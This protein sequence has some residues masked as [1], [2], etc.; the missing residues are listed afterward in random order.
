MTTYCTGFSS[1]LLALFGSVI[2]AAQTV[3]VTAIRADAGN[4]GA[5]V[6]LSPFEVI[7]DTGDAYGTTMTT[8]ATMFRTDIDKLPVTADV[9]TTQFMR[10]LD[11]KDLDELVSTFATGSGWGSLQSDTDALPKEPG[12]RVANTEVK[13]RGV[14]S[15][16]LRRDGVISANN[17]AFMDGFATESI[18]ILKGPNALMYAGAAGG[19]VISAVSKQARFGRNAT[20]FSFRLDSFGSK[21]GELDWSRSFRTGLRLVPEIAVRTALMKQHQEFYR[22]GHGNDAWGAYTQVAFRLPQ[23]TLRIGY[24]HSEALNWVGS[25]PTFSYRSSRPTTG[26]WDPSPDI[27]ARHTGPDRVIPTLSTSDLFAEGEGPRIA[28]GR[29]TLR[30]LNS[31]FISDYNHNPKDDYLIANLETRWSRHISS[32]VTFATDENPVDMQYT[33]PGNLYPPGYINIERPSRIPYDPSTPIGSYAAFERATTTD[34]TVVSLAPEF[35]EQHFRRKALRAALGA[36]W[37]NFGGKLKHNAVAGYEQTQLKTD[38][39][40]FFYYLA[41]ANWNI[42]VN[43]AT[44]ATTNTNGR[45]Q[46][47]NQWYEV[48]EQ[49]IVF[50]RINSLQQKRITLNGQ[51]WVL[52][53]KNYPGIWPVT[54]ANP[55]GLRPLT[56]TGGSFDGHSFLNTVTA[57]FFGAMQTDW[58]DDRVQTVLSLRRE[59][60]ASERWDY[61]TVTGFNREESNWGGNAGLNLR[62][63][64]WLR[65]YANYSRAVALPNANS[66]YGPFGELVPTEK[67]QGLETGIKFKVLGR[68]DGSFSYYA[69]SIKGKNTNN[70]LAFDANPDG[71]NGRTQP[72][73]RWIG[74]DQKTNGYELM[75]SGAPT[76]GW[77]TTMRVGVQDGRVGTQLGFPQVY[78]DEFYTDAAR[79]VTYQNGSV[80]RVNPT[81]IQAVANGGVPLTV[82][83]LND[84]TSLYYWDPNPR[85]GTTQNSSLRTLLQNPGSA[86]VTANGP[87]ATGRNGLPSSARQIEWDDPLGF[88]DGIEISRAGRMTIGYPRYKL[89]FT[90]TY[91]F[92]SGWWK[93]FGV[94]GV[95][96]LEL[97][98]RSRWIRWPLAYDGRNRVIKTTDDVPAAEMP[99]VNLPGKWY[100]TNQG[101]LWGLP[102]NTTFNMWLTYSRKLGREG[103]YRYSSQLNVNNVFDRVRLVPNP[104][105][106]T[107][108]GETR[109]LVM[110]NQPRSWSWT[111]RIEF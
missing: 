107:I 46:L 9:M 3:P 92:R 53:S 13:L 98:N 70:N 41:D 87:I 55:H 84:R 102:D 36:E 27:V 42:I 78:N 19:G 12:V 38:F 100:Y 97:E 93:A 65:P 20:D 59:E 103:R 52:Q 49:G 24:L 32:L 106:G 64:S 71:I 60:Y 89:S 58:F 54:P 4:K 75:F 37:T 82:A 51:N 10:D 88:S 79:N 56:A 57:A 6:V 90:N 72:S 83:M 47:R 7:A 80:V 23:S 34:W 101:L 86:L 28:N 111:N 1:A 29:L 50:Q 45:T 110:Q 30:N 43:P 44:V 31:A 67:S 48:G 5:A 68:I 109:G 96:N 74:V 76:P 62:V 18:E 25:S 16:A 85:T 61:R 105:N 40:W 2:A 15:G 91:N 33:G 94:G 99:R 108:F 63:A 66:T 81:S 22:D 69:T 17:S 95:V 39:D 104:Y 14:G 77:R 26:A 21:R 11:I 35:Y 73:E 8:S